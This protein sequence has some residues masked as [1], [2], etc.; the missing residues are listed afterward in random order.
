M[1]STT[2]P[3]DTPDDPAVP[4]AAITVRGR[5]ARAGQVL[6][7]SALRGLASGAGTAAGTWIVWWITHY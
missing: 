3:G 7:A 1:T 6:T 5:L 4:P 2:A